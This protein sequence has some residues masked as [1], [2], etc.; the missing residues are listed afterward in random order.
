MDNHEISKLVNEL[1]VWQAAVDKASFEKRFR[2][3]L[4]HMDRF[5]AAATKLVEAGI[6]VIMYTGDR[7]RRVA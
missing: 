4:D 6:P 5:D 7:S 1:L 2:D 3:M